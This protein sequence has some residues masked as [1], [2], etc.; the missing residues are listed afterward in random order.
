M[1]AKFGAIVVD[2]R[3]KIGGHVASK[4][5]A[6][7]YFRTKVTPANP[8][9]LAQQSVRS[10]FTSLAQSW[11]DLT[12]AQRASWVAGAVNF[13]YVDIFGDSK[14]YSG[15]G[16]FMKLNG[17]LVNAGETAL[18]S[19]PAPAE[20]ASITTFSAANEAMN[21]L[22]INF[23]PSPVP[24]GYSMVVSATPQ[25][26]NGKAF[27]K[28]LLRKLTVLAAGTASGL[29]IGALY[30]DK[31]GDMDSTSN[32]YVSAFLVNTTTGQVSQQVTTLVSY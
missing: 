18:T 15:F 27:S 5:K 21:D 17:N 14:Q 19:C 4:N 13:P 9:S 10:S 6:G 1:K 2:G 25:V 30:V 24:V 7:S 28:N 31:F 3:G 22:T 20:I 11:R 29:D 32:I 23:A 8:Q 16:L 26:S 12:A